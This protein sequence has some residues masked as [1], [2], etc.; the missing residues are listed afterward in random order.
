MG[1]FKAR[2]YMSFLMTVNTMALGKREK[3]LVKERFH[4]L[5]ASTLDNSKMEKSME[6]E[7]ATTQME[8]SIR[9]NGQK[10]SILEKDYLFIRMELNTKEN[11]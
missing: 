11:F 7:F 5:E 9:D 8:L 6:K 4:A 10:T 1:K 2:E 3:H